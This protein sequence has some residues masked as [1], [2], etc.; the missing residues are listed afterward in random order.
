[1]MQLSQSSIIYYIKKLV[2]PSA[3]ATMGR[4]T[5]LLNMTFPEKTFFPLDKDSDRVLNLR[6]EFGQTIRQFTLKNLIFIDES[7]VNLARVRLYPRYEKRFKNE[8]NTR[9]NP[10]KMFQ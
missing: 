8:E 7:G 3:L 9:K 6:Y 2:L 1:M 10:E 5:K 4:M